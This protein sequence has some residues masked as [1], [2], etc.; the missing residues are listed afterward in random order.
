MLYIASTMN[1]QTLRDRSA[2]LRV[3]M[4]LALL[5]GLCQ[6]G[7]PLII[8]DIEEAGLAH[9]TKLLL[10]VQLDDGTVQEQQL[11]SAPRQIAVHLPSGASGVV[12]LDVYGQNEGSCKVAWTR[13]KEAA[14]GGLGRWVRRTAQLEALPSPSCPHEL[15]AVR[16]M[17]NTSVVVVGN[18][19]TILHCTG[20]TCS[21]LPS[22][23]TANLA[24]VWRHDDTTFYAVGDG[25]TVRRCS[26]ATSTCSAL[27]AAMEVVKDN[28]YRV[29][30]D[31]QHIYAV[32][33]AG[34]VLQCDITNTAAKNTCER[35]PTATS[36]RT[37]GLWGT[38]VNIY[39]ASEDGKI[40]RCLLDKTGIIGL[41][42]DEIIPNRGYPPLYGIWGFE[43]FTYSV[44]ENATVVRCNG[45]TCTYF[46][47]NGKPTLN[48]VWGLEAGNVYAV[49]DGGA[50][51]RCMGTMCN[52]LPTV[53]D[54]TLRAVWGSETNNVYVV[55]D[56]GSVLRCQGSPQGCTPL[57]PPTTQNLLAVEGSDGNNVY[58]VGAGGTVVKCAAGSCTDLTMAPAE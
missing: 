31:A 54:K 21:Y 43:D 48:A 57:M 40:Q 27:P 13:L 46:N 6:C 32:G 10:R 7:Q 50:V 11:D 34:E 42:C 23:T 1:I 56:G 2:F 49:G 33:G 20:N 37:F 22:G 25:A 41:M 8:L 16:R 35:V 44:G 4:G 15:R 19:G 39:L 29:W 58:A 55:G 38:P 5:L 26:T 47:Q 17:N 52:M 28:L 9:V 30:G 14:P 18:Q 53:T 45:M 3:V 36:A 12:L 24:A 51:L